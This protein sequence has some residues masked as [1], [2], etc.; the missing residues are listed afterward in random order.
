MRY[1]H[2]YM[3]AGSLFVIFIWFL[4]DPDV[5]IIQNL[6]LGAS[7]VA[8]VLILLKSFLYVTVLHMSRKA[9]IDYIDLEEYFKKAKQSAEGAG[10]A[11]VGVGL[12]TIGL[13]IAMFAATG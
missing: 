9:L 8:T 5:G 3:Y 6:P 13:S 4:S 11:I 12:I 1:R 7:T 2:T 10:L